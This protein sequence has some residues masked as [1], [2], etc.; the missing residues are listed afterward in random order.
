[1]GYSL[2]PI[3]DDCYPWT[4]MLLNKLD[5]RDATALDEAEALMTLINATRLEE[6]PIA[7]DFNFEHY[8]AIHRFLFSDLL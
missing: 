6:S 4:S 7:G 2:D 8:K 3:L 1:M 5:I